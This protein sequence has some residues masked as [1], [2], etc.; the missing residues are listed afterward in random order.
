MADS[1][2][3]KKE[4]HSCKLSIFRG[5]L[6][7]G[8]TKFMGADKA[9]MTRQTHAGQ[10]SWRYV[11]RFTRYFVILWQINSTPVLCRNTSKLH[12]NYTAL[13]IS[14]TKYKEVTKARIASQ[15]L[16]IRYLWCK[17]FIHKTVKTCG[18][19]SKY[20]INMFP[21]SLE[22]WFEKFLKSY[23]VSLGRGAPSDE[24]RS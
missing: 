22:R 23:L 8:C 10:S 5:C 16:H 9:I 20:G 13:M 6:C 19:V 3:H 2:F 18:K 24:C 1:P 21:P 4:N 7:L 12:I 11:G 14:M 17:C 15:L